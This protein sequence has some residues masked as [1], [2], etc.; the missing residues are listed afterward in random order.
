[1]SEEE[2]LKDALLEDL[3]KK[4]QVKIPSDDFTDRIMS[5]IEEEKTSVKLPS[6]SL[7]LSW[8][9]LIIA[10]VLV[11]VILKLFNAIFAF[12]FLTQYMGRISLMVLLGISFMVLYQFDNLLG[13]YF[14][15]KE[16]G[17]NVQKIA[18]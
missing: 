5:R 16:N 11:P 6:F 12:P 17:I 15:K 18:K 4:S 10:V 1:M 3:M 14:R 9:L 7:R 13:V 8:I 2:N